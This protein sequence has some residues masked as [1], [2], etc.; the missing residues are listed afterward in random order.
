MDFYVRTWSSGAALRDSVDHKGLYVFIHGGSGSPNFGLL[1]DTA[2]G[3]LPIQEMGTYVMHALTQRT[4]TIARVGA[5][6]GSSARVRSHLHMH[7]RLITQ[8][9]M[10]TYMLVTCSRHRVVHDFM[11]FM[12]FM[13]HDY[14]HVVTCICFMITFMSRHVDLQELH[15]QWSTHT[16]LFTTPYVVQLAAGAGELASPAH[17]NP[18]SVFCLSVSFKYLISLSQL[19]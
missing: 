13:I 19:R 17:P 4:R 16:R 3:P 11:M 14:L 1:V 7:A 8:L 2:R 18:R 12:M 6:H 10:C 15:I 9:M 5:S